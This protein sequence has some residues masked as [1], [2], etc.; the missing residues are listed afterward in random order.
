MKTSAYFI[1]DAPLQILFFDKDAD[2]G[3]NFFNAGLGTVWFDYDLHLIETLAEAADFLAPVKNNQRALDLL[4]I[5]NTV[6]VEGGEQLLKQVRSNENLAKLPIYCVASCSHKLIS[7]D[8]K[9]MDPYWRKKTNCDQYAQ[10]AAQPFESYLSDNHPA[11][12][13]GVI[14]GNNIADQV[15]KIIED[16]NQY[17]FRSEVV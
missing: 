1:D 6:W 14:C 17:W 9:C 7:D 8:V 5:S 10:I 13:H 3:R 11:G 2:N 15:T 16:M 4:F 12:L